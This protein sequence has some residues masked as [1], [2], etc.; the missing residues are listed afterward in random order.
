[1]KR[2]LFIDLGQCQ[3]NSV[4]K[5]VNFFNRGNKYVCEVE[6]ECN[7]ASNLVMNHLR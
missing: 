1:M 7:G 4:D 3:N 5:T 6:G 2:S